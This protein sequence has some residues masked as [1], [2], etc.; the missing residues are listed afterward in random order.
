MSNLFSGEGPSQA[1]HVARDKIRRQLFTRLPRLE[2]S[3]GLWGP[4]GCK[5]VAEKRERHRLS[6][7]NYQLRTHISVISP[8]QAIDR[9]LWQTH[10][11]SSIT[12]EFRQECTGEA[13]MES[14]LHAEEAG[15]AGN[16]HAQVH[17][18]E[19]CFLH[20]LC[21][22]ESGRE[23]ARARTRWRGKTVVAGSRAY[24]D[25]KIRGGHKRRACGEG[26]FLHSLG[27]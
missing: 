14:V 4:P 25:C 27:L 2:R 12:I 11:L 15:V 23:V 6:S 5:S 26:A 1:L 19:R 10:D 3:K 20:S 16:G 7:A 22:Q 9:R 8:L 21:L 17:E 18:G 24:E 13:L